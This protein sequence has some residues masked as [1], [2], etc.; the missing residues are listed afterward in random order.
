MELAGVE[1]RLSGER[2]ESEELR[3][4]LDASKRELSAVRGALEEAEGLCEALSAKKDELT[5]QVCAPAM[6]RRRP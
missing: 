4:A 3:S 1:E 5:A 2:E 6:G